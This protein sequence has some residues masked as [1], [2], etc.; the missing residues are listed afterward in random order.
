[1][2]IVF[3]DYFINICLQNLI[4]VCVGCLVWYVVGNGLGSDNDSRGRGGA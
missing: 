1:M 2:Y 4:D 3:K